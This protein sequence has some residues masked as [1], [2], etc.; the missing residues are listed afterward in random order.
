MGAG[1]KKGVKKSTK[2]IAQ[3]AARQLSQEPLEILR[4]AGKQTV[5][6]QEGEKPPYSQRGVVESEEQISPEEKE[7][8]RQRDLSRIRDL[9]TEMKKI[10]LQ[11]EQKQKE[12]VLESEE[13]EQEQ[14]KKGF[15]KEPSTKPKRGLLAQVKGRLSRL[16]RRRETRLPPSG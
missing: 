13:E 8:I 1:I 10:R 5:G 9:E 2:Q 12:R 6:A 7:R 4:S 15:L 16:R 14:G 11:K 3:Q